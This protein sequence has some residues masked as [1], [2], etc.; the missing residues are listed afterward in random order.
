MYVVPGYI[1]RSVAGSYDNE[2]IAI[3]ALMFTYYLWVSHHM[4]YLN[5]SICCQLACCNSWD[6]AAVHMSYF[7]R[8]VP[9]C[10]GSSDGGAYL[11]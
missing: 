11:D 7:T 6:Y 10:L 1:S 5:Q 2:G 8:R 3:F 4:L 9:V